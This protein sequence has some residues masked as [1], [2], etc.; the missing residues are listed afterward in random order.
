MLNNS[1]ENKSGVPDFLTFVVILVLHTS[2]LPL[3]KPEFLASN[4]HAWCVK[5]RKFPWVP[6]L[7]YILTLDTTALK[8]ENLPVCVWL[9][10]CLKM[11]FYLDL[12]DMKTNYITIMTSHYLFLISFTKEI[13]HFFIDVFSSRK[14]IHIPSSC[15]LKS[16]KMFGK[17]RYY[18]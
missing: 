2:T 4:L 1:P 14:H 16:T 17:I 9:I 12:L 13:W 15:L 18:I 3:T 5:R 8:I 6:D 10:N 11:I 7:L